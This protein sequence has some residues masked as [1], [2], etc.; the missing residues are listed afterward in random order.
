MK[1]INFKFLSADDQIS[2]LINI[3]IVLSVLF[4]L[5][6]FVT[7]IVTN[8]KDATFIENVNIQYEE[9]FVG[10][11]LNRETKPY[12]VIAYD[13]NSVD[14]DLFETYI[15]EYGNKENSLSFY[16]LDFN[17]ILNKAFLGDTSNLKVGQSSDFV[18]ND[19]V[20]LKITD[21]KIEEVIEGKEQIVQTLKDLIN[22]ED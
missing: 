22:K 4:L 15:S 14:K 17:N 6:Y 19:S 9:V 2:K 3:F 5:F 16:K 1:K 8:K 18:F 21:S 7:T 20:I 11:V 10:N 12:Y 13:F